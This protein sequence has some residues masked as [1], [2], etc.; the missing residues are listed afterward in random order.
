MDENLIDH[1]RETMPDGITTPRTLQMSMQG[2]RGEL[3]IVGNGASSFI[4]LWHYI[5]EYAAASVLREANR[6]LVI[7]PVI[8]GG[9]SQRET[10][11]RHRLCTDRFSTAGGRFT[12]FPAKCTLRVCR[13][14]SRSMIAQ[15]A[16]KQTPIA[17]RV[18]S[19]THAGVRANVLIVPTGVRSTAMIRQ[20]A[21]KAR[22][23]T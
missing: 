19:I 7:H 12:E 6:R 22:R 4:P 10:L 9:D 1:G 15:S 21:M 13:S 11:S 23:G 18:G 20:C 3:F 8:T 2:R 14:L 16:V 17:S 5:P